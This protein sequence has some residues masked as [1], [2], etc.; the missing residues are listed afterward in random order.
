MTDQSGVRVQLGTDL[1]VL[2]RANVVGHV[3]RDIAGA[4]GVPESTQKSILE[5]MRSQLLGRVQIVLYDHREQIVGYVAIV[6]D[7]TK[8]EIVLSRGSEHQSYRI[9]VSQGVTG[10]VAPLLEKARAYIAAVARDLGV[11]RTMVGFSEN[12]AKSH[13]YHKRYT[14]SFSPQQHEQF[15]LAREGRELRVTDA[16][17]EEVAVIFRHVRKS[18]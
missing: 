1:A 16:N 14:G 8:H 5:G 7:W 13:E 6:V 2:T 4:A 11:T 9:D 18:R 3:A 12:P 10:Q 15:R 17:L